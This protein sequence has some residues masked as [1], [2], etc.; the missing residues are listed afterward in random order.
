MT[1][2]LDAT[3][4]PAADSNSRELISFR[5]ADQ[6]YCV[7]IM[8]VREIRGWS[9]AT[10]LPRSPDY[11]RGVLNLRGA[12]LPVMDLSARL[13]FAPASPTER[14]VI[15]V[16]Q[17]SGRLVGLLVDAVSDILAIDEASMQEPPDLAADRTRGFVTKVISLDG[18]LISEIA[19]E[20]LLPERDLAA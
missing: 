4:T 8:A 10:P 16:V 20:R 3:P 11:V 7:D 9:P 6:E 18:R 1:D 17:F 15:V 12:I 13:G 2:T 5:V 19:L 14:H